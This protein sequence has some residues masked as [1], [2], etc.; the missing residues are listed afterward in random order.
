MP[1]GG[2][3]IS[4]ILIFQFRIHRNLV[5]TF[6]RLCDEG[7]TTKQNGLPVAQS[8]NLLCPRRLVSTYGTVFSR[9]SEIHKP[10]PLNLQLL[11][12]G[13]S[14]VHQPGGLRNH[15]RKLGQGDLQNRVRVVCACVCEW[16]CESVCEC[17]V[18]EGVRE[19]ERVCERVCV[20]V[21]VRMWCVC[22]ITCLATTSTHHPC[23]PRA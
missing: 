9:F 1:L 10:N 13:R 8:L 16:V 3:L 14:L 5:V 19:C 12:C 7:I 15:S 2:E 21:C 18:R 4:S 6:I 20:R 23:S 11:L 17:G 22:L